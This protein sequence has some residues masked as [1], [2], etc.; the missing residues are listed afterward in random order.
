MENPLV[1]VIVA[2]YNAE[3]TIAAALRSILSQTYSNFELIVVDD[4]SDDST[5][6]IVEGLNDSRVKVV[7][8][9]KRLGAGERR[10][11]AIDHSR[12]KYIAVFDAD[13]VSYPERFA[14]QVVYLETHPEVDVVGSAAIVFGDKGEALNYMPVQETHADICSRPWKGIGLI[15]PTL[16]GKRVWF[17]KHRYSHV[18]RAQDHDM[19]LRACFTSRYANIPETLFGYRQNQV[20]IKKNIRSK[21]YYASS[22][23]RTYWK[24]GKPLMAIYGY[25]IQLIKILVY[26]IASIFRLQ[27]VLL[28]H[29][30]VP[31]EAVEV[32][33]WDEIWAKLSEQ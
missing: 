25:L 9:G 32:R 23:V 3:N 4:G 28:R 30:F 27:R 33:R 13:D 6:N 1:S 18:P 29:L 2:A 12:G 22:V 11:Q 16:M 14:K 5:V 15:H 20:P 21:W 24:L 31:A 8:D 10:N 17:V 26:I 7:S 19:L